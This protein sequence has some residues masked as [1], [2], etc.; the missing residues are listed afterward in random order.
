MATHLHG[1]I[2]DLVLT[3][4]DASGISDVRVAEFISDHALVL[5][6]LDSVNPPS[7]KTN[8]ITFRRYHKIDLDGFRKDLGKYS[9]V[10]CPGDTAS[11]LCEQYLGDLSKLLDKHAPLVT[12]TF[13]KQATGWLSDSYWLQKTIR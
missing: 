13:T 8:V 5:A 11:V 4:S 9:F 3:P 6:H 1:H 10:R 7:Q 12:R 2:L